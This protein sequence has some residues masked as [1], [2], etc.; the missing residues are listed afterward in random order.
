[1]KRRFG[2]LFL[3]STLICLIPAV[4]L[5]AGS[6]KIQFKTLSYSF[7]TVN[8]NQKVTYNFKFKNAGTGDLAIKEIKTSCDCAAV[9]NVH[10][11]VPPNSDGEIIATLSTGSTVGEK[12]E[13]IFVY[14]NDPKQS[15]IELKLSA[16]VVSEITMTPPE[17]DFSEVSYGHE[18]TRQV[19]LVDAHDKNFRVIK[20]ITDSPNLIA[21]IV[22]QNSGT[23][24]VSITVNSAMPLG[25]FSGTVKLY[26]NNQT[27]PV[28]EVPVSG[29]ILGTISATPDRLYFG[30]VK[31]G[32]KLSRTLTISSQGSLKFSILK[33]DSPVKGLT[34]KVETLTKGKEYKISAVLDSAKADRQVSDKV[35][36]HTDYAK[37]SSVTVP[38]FALVQ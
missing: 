34:F 21:K 3:P 18:A 17:L 35:T 22:S 11:P 12:N 24:F 36:I 29:E 13:S 37:Q 23:V 9:E 14:S 4:S 28:L 20:I 10:K 6:P 26:T 8:L 27:V 19:R 38:V 25:N 33:I 7:N 30:I 16:Q 1:M 15:P 31:K 5:A 32:D 2:F